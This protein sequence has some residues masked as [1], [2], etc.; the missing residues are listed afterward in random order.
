M[1]DY[2]PVYDNARPFAK[3]I[4]LARIAGQ[5][6]DAVKAELMAAGVTSDEADEA[7]QL[8]YGPETDGTDEGYFP[9]VWGVDDGPG[10]GEDVALDE[11]VYETL[12]EAFRRIYAGQY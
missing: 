6:F 4:H 8:A 10:L 9:E 7:I 11:C 5:G 12:K 2:N 3:K 1:K